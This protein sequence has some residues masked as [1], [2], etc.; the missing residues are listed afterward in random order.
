MD[1]HPIQARI[2]AD[3]AEDP[4][5]PGIS[6]DA[7]KE[8]LSR[9][10]TTVTIVAVRD[11][12]Q[13]HATTVS[14]F[15]PVSAEP[16][17]VLISLGAN[18]QVL[19]WLDPETRFTVNLLSEDQPRLASVFADSFPVGPS[20]FTDRGDPLIAEASTALICTVREVIQTG[21][22]A[23]LVLAR[24]EDAVTPEGKDPLLYYR[25]EYRRLGLDD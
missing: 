25:R 6:T 23:R 14:S 15:M 13:V 19:P 9:W 20:P 16:P 12:G 11:G 22:D 21:S 3:R 17:L 18:A 2:D 24:V 5:S 4:S 8:A 7:F 10:A 1:R